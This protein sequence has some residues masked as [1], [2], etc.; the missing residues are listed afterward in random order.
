MVFNMSYHS[1]DLYL[2]EKLRVVNSEYF[3]NFSCKTWINQIKSYLSCEILNEHDDV[4]DMSNN[5]DE[6]HLLFEHSLVFVEYLEHMH[7]RSRVHLE[8]QNDFYHIGVSLIWLYLTTST[9]QVL[10][11]SF[12]AP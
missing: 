7:I 9:N 2:S 1:K 11:V 12:R 8:E 10:Q 3:T 6:K 5:N 4:G